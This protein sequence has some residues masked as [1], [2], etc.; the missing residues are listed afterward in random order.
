MRGPGVGGVGVL[1]DLLADRRG[2]IVGSTLERR[3]LRLLRATR[4]PEPERQYHIRRAGRVVA[5][6]D[7]AYPAQRIAI[8]LDG[9]AFHS[10]RLSFEADRARQNRIVEAGWSPV[11]VTARQIADGPDEVIATVRRA[12]ARR[13]PATS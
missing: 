2:P 8:E 12:L 3:F 6:V 4:L 13:S 11:R 9:Y 10:G 7:F 5:R 1:A